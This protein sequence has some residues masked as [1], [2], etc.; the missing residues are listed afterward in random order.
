[1][2]VS[3]VSYGILHTMGNDEY[4]LQYSIA[5]EYVAKPILWGES[6]KLIAI[7]SHSISSFLPSDLHLMYAFLHKKSIAFSIKFS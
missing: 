4:F 5:W 3:M 2:G 7:L 6:G 1:M